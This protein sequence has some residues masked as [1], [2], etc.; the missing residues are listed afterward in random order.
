M[1]A[2][3]LMAIVMIVAGSQG[4]VYGGLYGLGAIEHSGSQPQN[5]ITASG[6]VPA[7]AGLAAVF[8]GSALF[9]FGRKRRPVP[10]ARSNE[11]Y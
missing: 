3:K 1:N 8:I 7:W 11:H 6:V 9:H 10:N 2:L 5:L 4:L